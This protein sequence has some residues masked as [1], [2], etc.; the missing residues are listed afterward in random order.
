M[1]ESKG[2]WVSIITNYSPYSGRRIEILKKL[3]LI[4]AQ[5][6][7][8]WFMRLI[9]LEDNT[10]FATEEYKG[11][12]WEQQWQA[13][14]LGNLVIL[15]RWELLKIGATNKQHPEERAQADLGC[16]INPN[17]VRETAL[18]TKGIGFFSHHRREGFWL[19]S[20]ILGLF[21]SSDCS[22][23]QD[24]WL[25]TQSLVFRK[26]VMTGR[27]LFFRWSFIYLRQQTKK[28]L[29]GI[30]YVNIYSHTEHMISSLM[31]I[32]DLEKP[33]RLGKWKALVLVQYLADK[34]AG[35][36]FQF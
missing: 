3:Y 11:P 12:I 33:D 15:F 34:L 29:R 18:P 25:F 23:F 21:F 36:V 20:S 22:S 26:W 9:G 27:H 5:K 4:L 6:A 32:T 24:S 30:G 13:E 31:L 35:G 10:F 14:I 16:G 1:W 2:Q 8:K 7:K 17:W 19:Q 28:Q